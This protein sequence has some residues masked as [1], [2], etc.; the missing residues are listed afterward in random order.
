MQDHDKMFY[1]VRGRG[2]TEE[3]KIF[4]SKNN[5]CDGGVGLLFLMRHHLNHW[6]NLFYASEL[7]LLHL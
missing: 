1:R 4:K 6:K 2:A 7:S 5:L 3:A